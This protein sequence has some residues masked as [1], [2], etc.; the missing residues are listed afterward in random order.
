MPMP[1]EIVG[2]LR[3]TV[4][5]TWED[6]HTTAYPARNLRLMCRCASCIE[7]MTGA[8]L[9]DPAKVPDNV[10]AR[11]IKVVGQYAINIEWSDNHNTGIYNFRD[12]RGNCPCEPC[13]ALRAAG[14][15]PE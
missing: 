7:E 3:S 2:L 6:G 4:T 15:T 14:K 11:N 8:P 5:I 1:T 13:T 12:L 10:R 9:L